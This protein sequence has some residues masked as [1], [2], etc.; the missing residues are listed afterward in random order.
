MQANALYFY[1]TVAC[2]LHVPNVNVT[3]FGYYREAIKNIIDNVNRLILI[4]DND[5]S[6]FRLVWTFF[7]LFYIQCRPLD[8]WSDQ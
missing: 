2:A 5:S 7:C 4:S 3:W 8:S 1:N 6:V